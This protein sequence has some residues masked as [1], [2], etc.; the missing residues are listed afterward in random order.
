MTPHVPISQVPHTGPQCNRKK[1][2]IK[3]KGKKG[4][5]EEIK[6]G[7]GWGSQNWE[8]ETKHNPTGWMRNKISGRVS[9][10]KA[11]GG[12]GSWKKKKKRN[13][14]KREAGP[15]YFLQNLFGINA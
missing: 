9:G 6:E 10:F 14:R 8:Q 15:G 11:V 13:E 7:G 12:G 5:S 4:V 2:R 1:G 3:A